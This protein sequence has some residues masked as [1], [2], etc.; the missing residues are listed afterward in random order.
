MVMVM[1]RRELLMLVTMTLI[2]SDL[3]YQLR[4]PAPMVV[5]MVMV[6]VM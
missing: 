4:F 3:V 5:V 6:M 1:M 2:Q